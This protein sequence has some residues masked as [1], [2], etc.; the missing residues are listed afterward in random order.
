[1]E[2]GTIK[3]VSA[4]EP[5][6]KVP[7][8]A[9]RLLG[10]VTEK[11]CTL[12]RDQYDSPYA[13]IMVE[14]HWEICALRS[15]QFALWLKRL[16]WK[17]EGKMIYG[18]AFNKTL[19]VLEARAFFES[20]QFPL[21]NRVTRHDGA[22]WYDLCDEKHR[23]IKVVA[24]NG[25]EI[26]AVP[27]IIFRRYRHQ[28]PIPVPDPTGSVHDIAPFLG[29]T[30]NNQQK[31]LLLLSII[32]CF[33]PDIPRPLLCISGEKGS[34]KSTLSRMLRRIV[35]P[36]KPLLLTLPSDR[37]ELAQQLS[38]HYFPIY[39]NVSHIPAAISDALCRAVTGD[40]FSKRQL[41]T[42]EEDVI[43][44]YR[45]CIIINGINVVVQRP[46]LLDRSILIDLLPI[47]KDER[48]TEESVWEDFEKSLP[49][50]LGFVLNTVSAAMKKRSQ[51]TVDSLPRMADFAISACAIALGMGVPQEEFL[52]AYRENISQQN[53]EAVHGNPLASAVFIL[54]EERDSFEDSPSE[55]LEA[56]QNVAFDEKIDMRSYHWPKGPQALL[57]RLKEVQGNLQEVGIRIRYGQITHGRR[58]ITLE[59]VSSKDATSATENKSSSSGGYGG[60][61]SFG[62]LFSHR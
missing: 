22:I 37:G 43:F 42:D 57:R 28:Q 31:F 24:E 1:M 46:D 2:E 45:R 51:V 40:G 56:L 52:K 5:K 44:E 13:R 47:K 15:V 6:K 39:D 35:D 8:Q 23:A 30:R 49:K 48:R 18:E 25:W 27:P 12:F 14:D 19:G 60:C 33:I 58:F 17:I 55:L 38:H 21:A 62:D 20:S 7:P 41:Y 16:F 34:S 10:Y 61:D 3:A 32:S 29:N 50:I 9:E 11:N 59:K 53:D 4:D 36:A 26:V 54:M